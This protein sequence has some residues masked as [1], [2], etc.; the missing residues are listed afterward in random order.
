V[1]RFERRHFRQQVPEK[2]EFEKTKLVFAPAAF[3]M[4][5]LIAFAGCANYAPM[6]RV[7]KDPQFTGEDVAKTYFQVSYQEHEG[8]PTPPKYTNRFT[9]GED[10]DTTSDI[11]ASYI[12]MRSAS[13]DPNI[14]VALHVAKS[15][16][17]HKY[18]VKVVWVDESNASN[19][20]LDKDMSDDYSVEF[21][22]DPGKCYFIDLFDGTKAD[23]IKTYQFNAPYLKIDL[24]TGPLLYSWGGGNNNQLGWGN[25]ISLSPWNNGRQNN[26]RYIPKIVLFYN[27]YFSSQAAPSTAT[28]PVSLGIGIS[29]FTGFVVGTNVQI[30][31][32]TMQGFIG[33]DLV[34]LGSSFL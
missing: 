9:V 33:L 27:I 5:C 17:T 3:F 8:S 12:W 2:M 20:I 13:A 18:R 14:V 29:V 15:D 11:T 19:L 10:P 6:V 23:P 16:T 21:K 32:H 31:N 22:P 24:Y 30:S 7:S 28:F 1:R 34:R 4:L 26:D 25:G